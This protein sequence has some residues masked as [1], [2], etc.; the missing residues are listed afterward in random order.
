MY[1]L[2]IDIGKRTHAAGLIDNGGKKVGRVIKF[3]PNRGGWEKL[4]RFLEDET[5]K[6]G[7]NV[8]EDNQ[9]DNSV[10]VGLEA[11]GHYWLT[12]YEKLKK[13][14]FEVTVFNPI[15]VASFRNKDI[16]GQKTDAI[17]AILIARVLRFGEESKTR[18][19][20]ETTLVLRRLSRFRLS[21]VDQITSTKKKILAILDQVFPEYEEC[22]E[23]TFGKGSL[24]LLSQYPL[25]EKVA[26]LD[27]RK[28]TNLLAK[29][30]RSH[31]GIEKA[32]LIQDK[33][34]KSFGLTIGLDAFEIQLNIL[35]DQIK[36]LEKQTT[37]IE[38]KIEQLV[39]DHV[40]LTI[41]GISYKT[42]GVILGE[43]G[44]IN[45]FVEDGDRDG[46]KSLTA[47]A[48][49]DAKLRE[50]GRFRG[51]VKMSKRGSKYLRRAVMQSSFVAATHDPMFKAIYEKQKGRGK[52]HFN[53]LSHVARK[54]IAVIYAVMRD[55]KAYQPIM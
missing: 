51:Q 8:D 28:L 17:D 24:A 42:A 32:K 3:R 36:H 48:G 16:R 5:I 43:I 10:K 33:A 11:T 46:V 53:A 18:L 30:S 55:Q 40:L 19:P 7:R 35:I 9:L 23:N 27:L 25:P 34:Q 20:K 41:P 6:D 29:A 50:S 45:R 12:I 52:H 14:G 15:Q 49:L 4:Q 1:Y 37:R 2:G 54:M 13:A 47:L 31:F 26:E 44:N 21:L 39:A 22:F 38:Q